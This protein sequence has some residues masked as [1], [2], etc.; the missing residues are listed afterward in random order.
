MVITNAGGY[1]FFLNVGC[2][3]VYNDVGLLKFANSLFKF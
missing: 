1:L 3:I 2:S